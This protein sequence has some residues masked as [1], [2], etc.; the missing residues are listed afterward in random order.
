M[1]VIRKY[2]GSRRVPEP[3]SI[4]ETLDNAWH[5]ITQIYRILRS[6]RPQR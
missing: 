1:C 2:P 3:T 5:M 4:G 6:K